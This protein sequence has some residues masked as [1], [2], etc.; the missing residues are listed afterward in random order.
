MLGM[1]GDTVVP[2][3]GDVVDRSFVETQRAEIGAV[4]ALARAAFVG[5]VPV[6]NVELRSSPFPAEVTTLAL[7]RAYRQLEEDG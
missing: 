6:A 7:E 5:G 4:A 3:H 2:G 1:I